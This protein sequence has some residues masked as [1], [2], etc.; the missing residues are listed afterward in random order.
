MD[1]RRK[2]QRIAWVIVLA[3]V[4]QYVVLLAVAMA[5]YPG[6]TDWDKTTRGYG[7]W[8]NSFSDLGRPVAHNGQAN[9]VSAALY[10]TAL[11]GLVVSFVPFWL[12]TGSLIP[13]LRIIARAAQV[14]GLAAIGGMIGTAIAPT[15]SD[16]NIHT[17]TIGLAAV[18]AVAAVALLGV[19]MFIDRA[20]PKRLAV[21]AVVMFVPVVAH[22]AQYVHHFWL[23]GPW[24]P[25][26]TTVQKF[27]ALA[28]LGWLAFAA[29][30]MLRGKKPRTQN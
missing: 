1:R 15:G 5:Y 11:I 4:V 6:G 12:V 23:N 22:F 18:P 13:N 9:A 28:V 21:A 20:C 27:M 30:H 3:G 10:P 17:I 7:F 16:S 25:A 29:A 26:C 8:H 19:G 14:L 2:W 24:T